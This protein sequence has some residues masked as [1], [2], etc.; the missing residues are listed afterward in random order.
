[1]G[2]NKIVLLVSKIK[3]YS[4]RALERYQDEKNLIHSRV[5]AKIS[6]FSAYIITTPPS[7]LCFT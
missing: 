4:V 2:A 3:L 6:K 1:M 5:T 7:I